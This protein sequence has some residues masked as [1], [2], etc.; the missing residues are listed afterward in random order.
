MYAGQ[1]IE[2]RVSPVG[3]TVYR[4]TEITH[5][6]AALFVDEQPWSV[7]PG[8]TSN[9]ILNRLRDADDRYCS[10]QDTIRFLGDIAVNSLFVK[11]PGADI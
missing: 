1:F 5:V 9:F 4:M 2:Y 6:E 7:Q 11:T 3:Y 8:T 10:L